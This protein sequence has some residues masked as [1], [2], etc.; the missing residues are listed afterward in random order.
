MS[1]KNICN[2]IDMLA[3]EKNDTF[4]IVK[5]RQKPTK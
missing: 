3:E 2:M 4:R 1:Q 5:L